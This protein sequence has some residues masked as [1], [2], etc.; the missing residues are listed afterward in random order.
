MVLTTLF[1]MK[2]NPAEAAAKADKTN[3][4]GSSVLAITF[5]KGI[6]ALIY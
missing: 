5:L 6:E 4:I 1:E 3:I 2:K